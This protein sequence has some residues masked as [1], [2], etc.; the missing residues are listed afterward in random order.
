MDDGSNYGAEGAAIN[1]GIIDKSTH[2]PH[3]I[4]SNAQHICQ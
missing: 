3:L 2:A 4:F 1:Y